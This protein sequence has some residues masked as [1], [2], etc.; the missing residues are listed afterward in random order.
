MSERLNSLLETEEICNQLDEHSQ[1]IELEL[2]QERQRIAELENLCAAY[3]KDLDD[4][5]AKSVLEK[6]I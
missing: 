1:Q 4:R 2:D 5:A 6:D 3:Q